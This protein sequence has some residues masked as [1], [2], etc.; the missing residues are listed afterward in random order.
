MQ[1]KKS[2]L[3]NTYHELVS[4]NAIYIIYI[5]MY[6]YDKLYVSITYRIYI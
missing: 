5:Y 4:K 1:I 3:Y 2:G 6:I